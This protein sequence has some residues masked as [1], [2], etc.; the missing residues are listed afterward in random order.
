MGRTDCQWDANWGDPRLPDRFWNKCVPEPMGGCWLWIGANYPPYGYGQYSI[1][2]VPLSAHRAAYRALVGA[3]P[4]GLQL[5]H[6]CR[7]TSCC[8]P[9][10]L[11]PVTPKEN[12]IRRTRLIESCPRGHRYSAE[13]TVIAS[14]GERR[15]R[16]CHRH[17]CA[18]SYLKRKSA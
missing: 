8:N 4:Q 12:S 11:E 9:L 3:I 16:E 2:G 13:N 17:F 14:K 18:Q 10:H 7:V 1:D 5:D 6:L 15:C